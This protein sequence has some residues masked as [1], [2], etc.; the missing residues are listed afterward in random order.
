M[1]KAAAMRSPEARWRRLLWPPLIAS[2]L[3]FCLPQA[4]FIWLSF[5]RDLGL[6]RVAPEFSFGNYVTIV[7]DPFY[8]RSVGLTALLAVEATAIGLLIGF[9]TAYALARLGNWI[10]KAALGLILTTSLIT[11]VIKLM[12]LNIL[13][14][15]SGLINAPLVAAGI[16]A[17]P[18]KLLDNEIGVV[19]GLVQYTLPLM[20]LVLFGVVQTIPRHLEEAAEIHGATRAAIFLRVVLPLAA[21]GLVGGGLLAFNMSMGAFT[22]PVALG[23]GHVL[24]MPVLIQ[25]KVIQ[26][27][28]Y[29]IGAA[30]STMLL[31]L[32]FAANVAIAFCAERLLG[33][34]RRTR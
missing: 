2:V 24:T 17:S 6:G 31:V 3:L 28:D 21:P 20:I 1:S 12:G 7:T 11:I 9:P 23:G 32:V 19:I 34:R 8:L 16:L 25:Q 13:L 5:H 4:A 27:S 30:L 29:A 22:S 10:T 33:A 14:G 26:D 18:L 15:G